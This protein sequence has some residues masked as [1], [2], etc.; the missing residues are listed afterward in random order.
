MASG[1]TATNPVVALEKSVLPKAY[2]ELGSWRIGRRHTETAG[3]RSH[4]CHILLKESG[5][6]ALSGQVVPTSTA[7]QI[8][9]QK[10]DEDHRQLLGEPRELGFRIQR[11]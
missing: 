3:C 11:E 8:M 7:G 4:L 5:R 6:L 9:L 1:V 10:Q 2:M